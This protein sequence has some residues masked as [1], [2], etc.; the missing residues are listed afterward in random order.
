ML[1]EGPVTL[2][3]VT[4]TM[5]VP[6][7]EVAVIEVAPLM[8]TLV[9]AVEPNLTVDAAVKFVPVMV[10]D[11]PPAAGPEVGL[12]EVTVGT[13]VVVKVKMSAEEVA[14]VPV[15]LVTV[16]FTVPTAPAGETAVI[17]VSL[18]MVKLVA[19]VEPKSTAVAVSKPVPVM[20]TE[21]SA[22]WVPDVGLSK[23]TVGVPS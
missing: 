18:L 3:T 6:A 14:E 9:A 11:V 19:A 7:G 16:T 13:G 21:V 5:P 2:V 20:A 22:P 23:V 15:A 17:E 8:V 4:F 1:V 10:T 12:I